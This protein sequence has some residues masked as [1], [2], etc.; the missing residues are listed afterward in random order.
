MADRGGNGYLP[1]ILVGVLVT[2]LGGLVLSFIQGWIPWPS[3]STGPSVSSSVPSRPGSTETKVFLN[4][5]SGPAGTLVRVSGEGFAAGET[6]R[7][8]F[9]VEQCAETVADASGTFAEVSC[10]IPG[11]W[12]FKGSFDIVANGAS[13]IRFASAPFRVT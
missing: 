12:R 4:R 9:H 2:V 10:R 11:D 13:S 5:L 8:R 3:S 6:V 7:I 1:Q